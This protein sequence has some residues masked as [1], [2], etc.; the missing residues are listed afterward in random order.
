MHTAYSIQLL[1]LI[2]RD[3]LHMF[4]LNINLLFHELFFLV[5]RACS[6]TFLALCRSGPSCLRT[7]TE[8]R[9]I[10]TVMLISLRKE[11]DIIASKDRLSKFNDPE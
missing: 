2:L 10:T 3:L 11:L 7:S 5:S 9:D 4:M 1:V 6:W 8:D